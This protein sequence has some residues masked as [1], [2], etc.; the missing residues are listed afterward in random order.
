MFPSTSLSRARLVLS[1]NVVSCRVVCHTPCKQPGDPLNIQ[2]LHSH[3]HNLT[4]QTTYTITTIIKTANV[5]A[6]ICICFIVCVSTT[7]RVKTHINR[8]RLYSFEP[9]GNHV[10]RTGQGQRQRPGHGTRDT[11]HG[12]K[13]DQLWTRHQSLVFC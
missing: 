7:D 13:Q 8:L 1:V 5:A 3:T 11:V 12:N 10:K 4:A 9:A 6:N 2:E